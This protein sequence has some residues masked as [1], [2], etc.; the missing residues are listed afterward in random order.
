MPHTFPLNTFS[1]PALSNGSEAE[2]FLTFSK[3]TVMLL[4]I[5]NVVFSSAQYLLM[6]LVSIVALK[7]SFW[8]TELVY[9]YILQV[10]SEAT[11]DFSVSFFILVTKVT[12][13][14]LATFV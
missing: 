8:E 10:R 12:K 13:T 2:V 11:D 14:T 5:L 6:G 4:F 3:P 9:M 7:I 1:M